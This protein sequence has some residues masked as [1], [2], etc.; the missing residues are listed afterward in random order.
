MEQE[1]IRSLQGEKES[2]AKKAYEI[3]RTGRLDVP[4]ALETEQLG[5]LCLA[6]VLEGSDRTR[7]LAIG[8]SK[9]LQ[10]QYGTEIDT[11]VD[12]L[13]KEY[14]S[15]ALNVEEGERRSNVASNVSRTSAPLLPLRGAAP[16]SALQA[17]AVTR[18][19]PDAG[20]AYDGQLG[21][22]VP[23][24][25]AIVMMTLNA[26]RL[27]GREDEIGSV[28]VGKYADMVVLDQNLFEI[29]PVAISEANVK[30]TIFG[31]KVVY[32]ARRDPGPT[33]RQASFL[34]PLGPYPLALVGPCALQ[35]H[36]FAR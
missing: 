7:A 27:M 13:E 1:R 8:A 22:P 32:D 16:N 28:E 23:L 18:R 34:S 12:A 31:G 9:K 14:A 5:A 33:T 36:L 21:Q 20:N 29:D 11:I 30:Q 15:F 4:A 26:S 25:D 19:N 6:A 17:G 35:A 2:I 24:E 10:P 3:Y